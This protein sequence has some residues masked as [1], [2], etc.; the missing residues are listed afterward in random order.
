[1]SLL[2]HFCQRIDRRGVLVLFVLFLLSAGSA[3]LSSPAWSQPAEGYQ[4]HPAFERGFSSETA[5]EVQV[6]SSVNLFNGNLSFSLPIGPRLVAEGD[7]TYGFTLAFNSSLWRYDTIVQICDASDDGTPTNEALPSSAFNAG[8][9]WTLTG[10]ELYAPGD[11]PYVD[12]TQWQLLSGDGALRAFHNK[13]HENDSPSSVEEG[14]FYTRD[15]SY[16]R[17]RT[18][19]LPTDVV[20][21]DHPNGVTYRFQRN[22]AGTGY[23][24]VRVEDAFGNQITVTHTANKQI[25]QDP[26]G[27]RMEIVFQNSA[28]ARRIDKVVVPKFGD[29][30]GGPTAVWD[31]HYN[32][33]V[34]IHRPPGDTTCSYDNSVPLKLAVDQLTGITRPD[35][36]SYSF[37]YSEVN[38][39]IGLLSSVDLPTGGSYEWTYRPY[40]FPTFNE[41]DPFKAQ[42]QGVRGVGTR[43]ELD[44][45]GSVLG[46]WSYLQK[47]ALDYTDAQGQ[48]EFS[49]TRVESP[50]H[51]AISHH[52]FDV[53]SRW[54]YGLAFAPT[55]EDPDTGAPANQRGLSTLSVRPQESVVTHDNFPSVPA[56]ALAATYLAY[57]GDPVLTAE[58]HKNN[59]RVVS[60]RQYRLESNTGAA[61]AD[62]GPSSAG[63]SA[64]WK[65]VDKLDFDGLGNFRQTEVTGSRGDLSPTVTTLAGF[66]RTGQT[67]T[68]SLPVDL[69]FPSNPTPYDLPAYQTPWIL[70]IQSFAEVRQDGEIQRQESDIDSNTGELRRT[71]IFASRNGNRGP[72]DVVTVSE[73]DNATGRVL[74]TKTYGGDGAGLGIGALET[75]DLTNTTP[76]FQVDYQYTDG[77]R[78]ETHWVDPQNEGGFR[79]TVENIDLDPATGLVSFARVSED[80]VGALTTTYAYDSLGRMTT[81]QPIHDAAF[82]YAYTPSSGGTGARLT[83]QRIDS[84]TVLTESETRFDGLGR[85]VEVFTTLPHG[86]GRQRVATTYDEL[87]RVEAVTVPHLE[88][89]SNPAVSTTEYDL[90]GRACRE[91]AADS[92][93]TTIRTERTTMRYSRTVPTPSNS[94]SS[95]RFETYDDLGR[96]RVVNELSGQNSSGVNT[97]YFYDVAGQLVEVVMTDGL[98]EAAGQVR[99]FDYDGRG[100]LKKQCLPEM[101]GFGLGQEGCTLYQ[102]H[103]ALGKPSVMRTQNFPAYDLEYRYD[104]VGRLIEVR[105]A[106][107]GSGADCRLQDFSYSRS[108]VAN[109][110]I[111]WSLDR[112]IRARQHNEVPDPRDPSKTLRVTVS[113]T[114]TYE[115]PEGRPSKRTMLVTGLRDDGTGAL[116]SSEGTYR[117]D[118]EMTYDRLGMVEEMS[119]PRCDQRWCANFFPSTQIENTYD[120]G[121]LSSVSRLGNSIPYADFTYHPNGLL[122]KI[123]HAN[124]VE[125][126]YSSDSSGLPRISRIRFG[127]A[128]DRSLSYQ[129]G[130]LTGFGPDSFAY[131]PVGRLASAV[132]SSQSQSTTV[133]YDYDV[134][135]NLINRVRDGVGA[136]RTVDLGSNRIVDSSFIYDEA[137][138]LNAF[139]GVTLTRDRLG[140]VIRSQGAG[141]DRVFIYNTG[142]ERVAT[143]AVGTA[144]QPPEAS[145]TLRGL[146]DKVLRRFTLSESS[147]GSENWSLQEDIVYRGGAT[148]ARLRPTSTVG[149]EQR[150]HYHLDHLGSARLLTDSAGSILFRRDYLPFGEQLNASASDDGVFRFTSHERDS[151]GTVVGN[152]DL[153]YMHA[154]Y[155][156]SRL[157]RFLSLDP[158]AANPKFPQSWNRYAYVLNSPTT[159][160]DEYG[161][162]ANCTTVSEDNHHCVDSEAVEVVEKDPYHGWSQKE[163]IAWHVWAR[164]GDT[165]CRDS[166]C[167]VLG[168]IAEIRDE[169]EG[170]QTG[171]IMF[172][173]WGPGLMSGALWAKS[174]YLARQAAVR[175][176]VEAA[177]HTPKLLP[178]PR[179]IEAAWGISKYKKGGVMEGMQHIMHR[180]SYQSGWNGVS[181]FSKGTGAKQVMGYVDEALRYGKVSREG[182]TYT[183]EHTFSKT[184]GTDVYGNGARSL[185]LFVRDGIIQTAYPY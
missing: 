69:T 23:W 44:L 3:S 104:A 9:G 132:V 128:F 30:P 31:F 75:L 68:V 163:K 183:V 97:S 178:A 121:V 35:G 174:V 156:S 61:C 173:E 7:L 141:A 124:G 112:L 12:S 33:A 55:L 91:T 109:A 110:S 129:H 117:F 169:V 65:Q 57:E 106:D 148:L 78:T 90:M 181:R 134:A 47:L 73:R 79:V 67:Y 27:R 64:E 74:K 43:R 155:Y 111:D 16:L 89:S 126:T 86:A 103:D 113:E 24:L 102:G 82:S 101:G 88:G 159:L 108:N 149:T 177:K 107:C 85:I 184:I 143:Y 120:Q 84:G 22:S 167:E 175:T 48:P 170:L 5:Y 71:R 56:Q 51:S 41:P 38:D 53:Q 114:Y 165:S 127:S 154:R 99:T 42:L 81:I 140:R 118:H 40:H 147:D 115:G 1:M 152:L 94:I 160:V 168:E 95:N 164:G 62:P 34:E 60:T 13:L 153:D 136:P 92:S 130:Y 146:D 123:Q 11:F 116:A 137:G 179:Q 52:Y 29:A 83:V 70:G 76:A 72:S 138:Y 161:L 19:S 185:R 10:G 135:G 150:V 14:V 176:G 21:V 59:H 182:S 157:G 100:F 18:I 80:S 66:D 142:G 32:T 162:I 93:V 77:L 131:D 63:P 125:D 122:E 50:E 166:A 87:G 49:V 180:H 145:F 98:A 133:L 15:S 96:L 54:S 6:D 105:K 139:D 4:V 46:E 158:A 17:L 119:Y 25:W 26:H 45:D 39:T 144:S 28:F 171:T 8:L 37:H 58:P 172:I 151:D 36:V 20:E 2:H